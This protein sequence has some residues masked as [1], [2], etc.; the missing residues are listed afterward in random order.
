MRQQIIFS[1]SIVIH[2]LNGFI[3]EAEGFGVIR[4]NDDK[5]PLL[6]EETIISVIGLA[7]IL[8][9]IHFRLL[10]DG[11]VINETGIMKPDYEH[12]KSNN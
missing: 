2:A 7:Q 6:L 8:R 1:Y 5:P 10:N 3:A 11:Y 12:Q 4:T 9:K